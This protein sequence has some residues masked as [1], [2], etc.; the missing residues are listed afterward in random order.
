MMRSKKKQVFW[1]ILVM[2]GFLTSAAS[3][4]Q[5]KSPTAAVFPV[6]KLPHGYVRGDVV[7]YSY[8]PNRFW[9]KTQAY[10]IVP[11]LFEYGLME[12]KDGTPLETFHKEN[13]KRIDLASQWS[14]VIMLYARRPEYR[15]EIINLMIRCFQRRQLII[16]RDYFTPESKHPLQN[17]M[18]IL[19]KLWEHRNRNLTSPEGD[20]ATGLQLINNILAVKL[21][22]ENLKGLGTSGLETM[23]RIFNS[24]VK[25]RLLDGRRP[26]QHIKNWYNLIG[27]AIGVY[28]ANQ[29]DIQKG[30]QKLPSNAD[31]I[32]VD[33]YHWY[34]FQFSPFDPDD[35]N[36]PKEKVIQ[37]AVSWQ[38]VITKYRGPDFRVTLGNSWNPSHR[39][40]T[41]AMLQGLE[42]AKADR[43]MMIFIAASNYIKGCYTTPVETM[44]AYYDSIK[45]GPWIGLCW[46]Y[47]SG[48]TGTIAYID[49]K[50]KHYTPQNPEGLDYAKERL[51]AYR[52]RLIQS[53][54]RIFNDVVYRQFRHLNEPV[55]MPIPTK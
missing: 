14:T 17:L 52:R 23:N 53:R 19:Q 36:V 21:G 44:D 2:L 1:F 15:D 11:Y 55:S 10:G 38:N 34:F 5:Y 3:Y 8:V 29:E 13:I 27:Y 41:H 4:G 35:P 46:W 48:D 54:M 42:L 43:T 26:F 37:H 28:A 47:F 9:A 51:E 7:S 24:T 12:H 18:A 6:E 25:N 49:K 45:A 50:L 40:D 30:R 22:D 33:V 39:N 31:F 32:G 16:L 20:Q